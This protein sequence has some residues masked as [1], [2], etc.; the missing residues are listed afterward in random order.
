[1]GILVLYGKLYYIIKNNKEF[2]I[3][4]EKKKKIYKIMNLGNG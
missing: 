3:R 4:M 1:M 2:K